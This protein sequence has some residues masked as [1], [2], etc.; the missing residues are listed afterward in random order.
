MTTPAKLPHRMHVPSHR[1]VLSL[2]LSISLS[3]TAAVGAAAAEAKPSAF[4]DTGGRYWTWALTQPAATNPVTD[5]TG[6]FCS[7]GQAG[8]TW[9]LAGTLSSEPV[10]RTC[11]V[12]TGKKVV[13]PVVNNGYFAF[14]DDPP[15]QR[16]ETF[17]R[18]QVAFVKDQATAMQ[19]SIDGRQLPVQRIRYEESRLFSITLPADNLFGFA[20][21]FLLDPSVDAG[22]YV[23]LDPLE[24]GR[25]VIRFHGELP[26][27]LAVDVTYRLTVGR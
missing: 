25:H 5:T 7:Q 16:T 9:F 22:Y 27:V 26:A 21:G 1:A 11:T 17:V 23:H 10:A 6:Q 3:V 8:D 14:V 20:A 18:S 12:P 4:T 13:F 19:V 15:E 2:L 24:P